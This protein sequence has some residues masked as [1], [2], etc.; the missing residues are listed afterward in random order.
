MGT[1]FRS[2]QSAFDCGEGKDCQQ[3]AFDQMPQKTGFSRG[4]LITALGRGTGATAA[5]EMGH[6]SN[7]TVG[8]RSFTFHTTTCGNCYDYDYH[9]P[10]ATRYP[11]AYFLGPLQWTPQAQKD[12]PRALPR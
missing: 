11:R 2:F 7:F 6:Q 12:M 9:P 10:Q 4:Q 3:T 8:V 5:H 1:L